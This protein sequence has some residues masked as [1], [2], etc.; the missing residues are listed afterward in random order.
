MSNLSQ[1]ID[2]L[3]KKYTIFQ[4]KHSVNYYDLSIFTDVFCRLLIDKLTILSIGKS[5]RDWG[6][7]TGGIEHGNS[8]IFTDVFCRILIDELAILSIGKSWRDWGDRTGG[9]DVRF[10]GCSGDRIGGQR[11][12]A[13]GSMVR[14]RSLQTRAR[15]EIDRWWP[16]ETES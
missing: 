1:I 12:I 4:R 9:S 11:A 16:V 15:I 13:C 5:W 8:S 6:D 2:C 10:L 3:H 14:S 7:R